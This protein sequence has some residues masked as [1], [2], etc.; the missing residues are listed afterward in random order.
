MNLISNSLSDLGAI[1]LLYVEYSR[2][3]DITNEFGDMNATIP[4]LCPVGGNTCQAFSVSGTKGPSGVLSP[5]EGDLCRRLKDFVLLNDNMVQQHH[6]SKL[7]LDE[8]FT[9]MIVQYHFTLVYLPLV[10][11]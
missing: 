7:T 2:C 3:T 11:T 8:E 9:I 4:A 10:H 1:S 5:R 6:G